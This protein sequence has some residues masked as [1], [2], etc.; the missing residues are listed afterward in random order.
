MGSKSAIFDPI[1]FDRAEVESGFVMILLGQ[2][3]NKE[4][5]IFLIEF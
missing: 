1:E 3:N 2:Q 5:P 4:L